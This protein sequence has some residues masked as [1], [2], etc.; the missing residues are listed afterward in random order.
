[1]TPKVAEAMLLAISLR[2]WPKVSAELLKNIAQEYEP[3]V[4]QH[5]GGAKN[6]GGRV[7]GVGSHDVAGDMAASRFEKSVFLRV[8]SVIRISYGTRLTKTYTSNVASWDNSGSSDE[9]SANVGDDSAVQVGHD[10]DVE[11]LGAGNEL[12]GTISNLSG[13]VPFEYVC[14]LTCCRQSCHCIQFQR[15]CIPPRPVGR[16]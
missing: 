1:M 6:H 5:H 13:E 4:S 14:K 3:K 10:H 15:T 7:G 8:G 9:S 2:L 12:H 11:L 16:C